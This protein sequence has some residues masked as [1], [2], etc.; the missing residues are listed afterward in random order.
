M[1]IAFPGRKKLRIERKTK[2]LYIKEV[3]SKKTCSWQAEGE[4]D[5]DR[6]MGA[7][8]SRSIG[9]CG[10]AGRRGKTQYSAGAGVCGSS[11]RSRKN[12][13]VG[14][15]NTPKKR[16]QSSVRTCVLPAMELPQLEGRTAEYRLKPP[17]DAQVEQQLQALAR[18]RVETSEDEKPARA[19]DLATLDFDA[20]LEDGT[21]FS[22]SMGRDGRYHLAV[23][24]ELPEGVWQAVVGKKA[25]DGFQCRVQLPYT[26]E[27]KRAAG[28]NAVYIGW[29]KKIVHQRMPE[30]NDTFAQSFG[31]E[32]MSALRAIIR[33]SFLEQEAREARRIISQRML[34]ALS[35]ETIVELPQLAVELEAEYQWRQL[36]NRL[37]KSGISLESHLCR[38]H[39]TREKLD[40]SIRVHAAEDMKLRAVFLAVARQEGLTVSDAETEAAARAATRGLAGAQIDRMQLR[41]RLC[42]EKGMRYVTE[43]M[44]LKPAKISI[45]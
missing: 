13:A 4:W 44:A 5:E 30:L 11:G 38:L 20:V 25:G 8:F 31:Q 33:D 39:K 6:K 42:V 43:R 12:L 27:D 3:K 34:H 9:C 21:R 15:R 41:Q 7:G 14:T 37:E 17:T 1:K 32:N 22:G 24:E 35:D 19:G 40:A 45:T 36:E 23:G 29:V 26:Y 28:K 16:K 10:S 2:I 18:T